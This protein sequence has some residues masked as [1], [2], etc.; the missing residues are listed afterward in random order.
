MVLNRFPASFVKLSV[1]TQF[2]KYAITLIKKME[3]NFT[4]IPSK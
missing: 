1:T 4:F 3:G 2:L